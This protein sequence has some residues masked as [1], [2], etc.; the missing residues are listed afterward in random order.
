MVTLKWKA[1]SKAAD[2]GV[3]ER[4]RHGAAGV[5]DDDVDAAERLD[6]GVH[7]ALEGVQVAHVGD[8]GHG[9]A[10]GGADVGGDLVQLALGPGGQDH[11]GADVGVGA[12][13]G[14]ADAPA[15]PGDDGHL[16]VESKAIEHGHFDT[17][18]CR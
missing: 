10:A 18:S 7:Q 4:L 13:D 1:F 2:A 14:G 16:P 11:V 5:V 9:L 17:L 15:T 3:Q 8:D 12:G 6:G